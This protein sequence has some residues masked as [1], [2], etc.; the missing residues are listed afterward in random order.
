MNHDESMTPEPIECIKTA[1]IT[2]IVRGNGVLLGQ[3]IVKRPRILLAQHQ[4]DMNKWIL[5]NPRK[6]SC[7]CVSHFCCMI[8]KV[9]F[10]MPMFLPRLQPLR[11]KKCVC[12][13]LGTPKT[14]GLRNTVGFFTAISCDTIFVQTNRHIMLLVLYSIVSHQISSLCLFLFVPSICCRQWISYF[15]DPK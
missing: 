3:T 14:I 2:T 9:L 1:G 11:V 15:W 8:L 6:Q 7:V 12:P 10:L 13:K 4:F 5:L